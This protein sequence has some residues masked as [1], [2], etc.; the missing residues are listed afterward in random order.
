MLEKRHG[1]EA[2]TKHA[3]LNETVRENTIQYDRD[4]IA[5]KTAPIYQFGE[6]VVDGLDLTLSSSEITVP[7]YA[8]PIN[9]DLPNP[10]DDMV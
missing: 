3:H 6:N 4:A 1:K 2:L 10:Y 9:I 7:G 8:K 5:G